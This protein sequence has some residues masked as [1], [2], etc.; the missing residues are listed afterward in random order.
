MVGTTTSL[1]PLGLGLAVGLLCSACSESD[2]Q[3]TGGAA[4]AADDGS[5]DTDSSP[6]TGGT[7]TGQSDDDGDDDD[8]SSVDTTAGS[9]LCG[10]QPGDTMNFELQHDGAAV[11]SQDATVSVECGG[12]G[13]FMFNFPV[14]IFGVDMVTDDE[15]RFEVTIDVGDYELEDGHFMDRVRDIYVGCELYDGIDPG[16]FN[17]PLNDAID[18]P[19]VLDGLP[20]SMEF[21]M[22]PSLGGEQVSLS[23]AGTVSATAGAAWDWCLAGGSGE[24][25][26][27][28]GSDTGDSGTGGSDTG[29]SG[30]GGSGTAGSGTAG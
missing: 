13:S 16:Q 6:A 14:E 12:Q 24:D 2:G 7:A 4:D 29:D 19:S 20:L 21:V 3:P 23:Y 25:P 26:D 27:T 17:L 9:M 10:V 18:D 8:T 5:Q 30:T 22:V 15:I 11:P 1:I 28:G